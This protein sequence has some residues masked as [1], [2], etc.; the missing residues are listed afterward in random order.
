MTM[1]ERDIAREY[2]RRLGNP[3]PVVEVPVH[4]IVLTR[5]E[6][7]LAALPFHLQHELDGAPYI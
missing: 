4:Q 3:Q 6:V 5:D 7:D 2:L 1:G